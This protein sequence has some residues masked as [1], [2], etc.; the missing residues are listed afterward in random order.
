MTSLAVSL[1]VDARGP[2]GLYMLT[3]SRITWGTP[4]DRWDGGQKTFCSK[5]FPDLF[6]YCGDA[7][8]PPMMLRQIVEQLDLGLLCADGATAEQRH[9]IFVPAMKNA[10][11]RVSG[12]PPKIDFAVYHGARCGSGMKA[13]FSLW[14][15]R[16]LH[17]TGD[18]V[19][20]PRDI[21]TAHSCLA[22]VD[23]SGAASIE[24]H[25]E[26]WQ[27]SSAAKTNRSSV[28]AFFD[29]LRS[30]SDKFSG[31]PPQMV[32]VWRIGAGRQFGLFW[33]GW[34]YVAGLRV[35]GDLSDTDFR[36]F[37]ESFEPCDAAGNRLN[38]HK[39]HFRPNPRG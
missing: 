15:T 34:P 4:A 16:H 10:I 2:C 20:T 31:G 9:E 14:E 12:H 23:G 11:N 33:N 6:G 18:W 13:K 24:R 3:D 29:S 30:N 38:P 1:S 26:K 37:D 32:G 36:W 21:E 22:R 35:V 39:A 7:Y 5:R 8:F 17:S 25:S 27:A 28:W 19:D